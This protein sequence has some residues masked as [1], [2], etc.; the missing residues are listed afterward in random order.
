M[1][2][3]LY[4]EILH[5]FLPMV[6]KTINS[7]FILYSPSMQIR[8]KEHFFSLNHGRGD[9][10]NAHDSHMRFLKVE[11]YKDHLFNIQNFQC[12]AHSFIS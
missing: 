11:K 2:L 10:V 7:N 12:H 1:S 4:S 3:E 6:S 9:I 8:R 5:K